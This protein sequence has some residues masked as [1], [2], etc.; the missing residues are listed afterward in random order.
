MHSHL[1]AVNPVVLGKT[2]AKQ[3]YIGDSHRTKCMPILLHGDGSFSGQ[4]CVHVYMCTCVRLSVQA[5]TYIHV[6][7]ACVCTLFCLPC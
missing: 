4:V 6:M 2:R 7:H 3:Y 5:Y 1:E